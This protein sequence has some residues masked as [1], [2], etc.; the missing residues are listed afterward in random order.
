MVW[1]G[2]KLGTRRQVSLVWQGTLPAPL[3]LQDEMGMPSIC[4][5]VSFINLKIIKK[6]NFNCIPCSLK[7]I[8]S[9]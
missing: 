8:L 1:P 3:C 4:L 6:K 2:R 7:L 9:F 5:F